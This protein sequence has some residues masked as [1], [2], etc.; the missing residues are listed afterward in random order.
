MMGFRRPVQIERST[1]GAWTKDGTWMKGT[2]STVTVSASV[3]PLN[4]KEYTMI[5][6]EGDHTVR[7]V[8]IYTDTA[9]FPAKEPGTEADVLLWRGIRWRI[10]QCDP[11]QS[12]VISHFRAY[13]LEVTDRGDG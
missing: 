13:A 3:Q 2:V 1:G 4:A 11:F 10:V 8:K 9:L 7:A 12:G 5:Q 6:P